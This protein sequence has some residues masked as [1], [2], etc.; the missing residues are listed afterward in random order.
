MK[1]STYF[2]FNLFIFL[3]KLIFFYAWN[4]K[5]HDIWSYWYSR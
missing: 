5:F 2:I 1:I 4:T 3:Q